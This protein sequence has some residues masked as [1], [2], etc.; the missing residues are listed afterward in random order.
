M[1]FNWKYLHIFFII[2]KESILVFPLKFSTLFNEKHHT[3]F[4][5]IFKVI[6]KRYLTFLKCFSCYLTK[7]NPFF[8]IA[9][10][11]YPIIFLQVFHII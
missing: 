10:N 8:F 4:S 3:F 1:L 6:N 9:N 7:S 11:K 2:N 5:Q